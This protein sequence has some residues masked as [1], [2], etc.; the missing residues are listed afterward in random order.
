M[1]SSKQ[2]LTLQ[3]QSLRAGKDGHGGKDEDPKSERRNRM[4]S[5]HMVEDVAVEILSQLPIKSL[6]RFKSLSK[7]YSAL[8]RDHYFIK[9]HFQWSAKNPRSLIFH[10]SLIRPLQ[11]RLSLF[12]DELSQ[13]PDEFGLPNPQTPQAFL[14]LGLLFGTSLPIPLV[15]EAQVSMYLELPVLDERAFRLVPWG[16]C[17]G[18]FCL[19]VSYLNSPDDLMLWNPATREVK[20]LPLPNHLR[21]VL[22][23]C[24]H[25]FGIDTETNDFKVVC[26]WMAKQ[27]PNHLR[28]TNLN[29]PWVEVYSLK[30]NSWKKIDVTLPNCNLLNPVFVFNSYL[31]GFYHWLSSEGIICFDMSNEVFSIMNLPVVIAETPEH[32]VKV[33]LS[34]LNGCIAYVL[35]YGNWKRLSYLIE[36]RR[37]EIWVMDN[38]GVEE[39]W[40][41]H[42]SI[43][44]HLGLGTFRGS[45]KDGEIL[46][47]SALLG[48][49][50]SYNLDTQQPVM[51]FPLPHGP[52]LAAA[53]I[54][55]ESVV[56]LSGFV[57]E[58][59]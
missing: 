51:E 42:F 47:T 41:K 14:D 49:L 54:Y 55:V 8:I 40:T 34:V 10:Y 23:I 28:E 5:K 45:L 17:M 16:L 3:I 7:Y 58:E 19:H 36:K 44:P 39:S 33:S 31:N 15:P 12:S 29:L 20:V 46:V 53:F 18:I 56:R 21:P 32:I 26:I 11:S 48:R 52:F 43:G 57:E 37:I 22:K 38:Y 50:L 4:A 59:A 24:I 25:G 30:S 35:E 27:L 2:Y 13:T 6:M 9:K 1:P